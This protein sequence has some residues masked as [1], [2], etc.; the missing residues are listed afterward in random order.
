MTAGLPAVNG[1]QLAQDA[2]GEAGASRAELEHVHEQAIGLLARLSRP[3]RSLRIQV[4]A[5]TLELTWAESGGVSAA[6]HAATPNGGRGQAGPAA[7]EPSGPASDSAAHEFLRSPGVGVFY[8]ASE[9]GAAPFVSVGTVIRQGQQIGIIEAMKLM[10]PVEAD[11]AGQV[12]AILKANGEPVE[13][14]EPLFALAAEG[15]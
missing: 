2:S 6:D 10:I 13:Y 5:V 1:Q 7:D 12:T 4:G 11:L 14:G 3:P 9:P 8:H 15:A